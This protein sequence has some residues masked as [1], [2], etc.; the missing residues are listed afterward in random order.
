MGWGEAIG[1]IF[2]WLP[3]REEHRRNQIDEIKREMDRITKGKSTH[4]S[5]TRYEHLSNKLRKL[6]QDA[7]NA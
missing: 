2:N 7:T 3:R 5:R 4:R 6:E 1:K